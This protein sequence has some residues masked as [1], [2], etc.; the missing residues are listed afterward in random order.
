MTKTS[1]LDAV[2]STIEKVREDITVKL[3]ISID[4]RNTL[5]EA[6]E[7]VD[8]ALAFQ[9]RGI[10][11]I[12]LCGDCKAGIFDNLRPAFERAKEHGFPL[13]L[14]FNEVEENVAEAP[15]LL[16]IKPNRLGHA[17]LLDDFCRKTIYEEKIPIEVCMTSNIL[18]ET[19]AT[20]EEHH[21]KELL[22]DKHPFIICVGFVGSSIFTF[23]V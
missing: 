23:I 8:L 20:F 18:C 15:S 13:T 14:H 1:Y 6:E 2:L 9:S 12:D 7:V 4:R 5:K 16:S 21:I 10:V 19:V 11:G 3:I 17:T 22:Q